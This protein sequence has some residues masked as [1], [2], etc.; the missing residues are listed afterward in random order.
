MGHLL[1][2]LVAKGHKNVVW[3]ADYGN[4]CLKK[5]RRVTSKGG[6]QGVSPLKL[7]KIEPKAGHN[8][9]RPVTE[10]RHSTLCQRHGGIYIYIHTISY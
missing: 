8:Y 1:A 7:I 10:L 4:G 5:F 6:S 9:P 2:A 3:K